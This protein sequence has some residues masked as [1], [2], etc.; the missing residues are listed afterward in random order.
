MTNDV[1]RAYYL[2]QLGLTEWIRQPV[3]IT[4]NHLAPLD[5]LASEVSACTRCVLHQS[6]TQT[7]FARGNPNSSLMIIGEAPGFHEDKEGVPFIGKAGI[8]L[9]KML[10]SIGLSEQS[11]YIANV[12]KCRPPENR[13]PRVEEIAAC[14]DYLQRQITLVN[15]KLILAVGRFAGQFL[16]KQSL[17]LSKMRQAVHDYEGKPV[18]VSY[19][20]AYLLRNAAEKRNAY[21]DLLRVKQLLSQ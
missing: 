18:I 12:L 4:E 21:G 9:N 20:P 7:V 3:S 14:Q 10:H 1:L 11:V 17:S 16:L 6:R 19:H 13:D 2:R 15:P 5:L 8:L